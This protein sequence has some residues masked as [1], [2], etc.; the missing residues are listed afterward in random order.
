METDWDKP[1]EYE[2]NRVGEPFTAEP[3]SLD[4]F[5]AERYRLFAYNKKK[6][7]LMSGQVHHAPYP[8]QQVNLECYS[9]RLFVLNGL[10]KPG[11][12]PVS[13]LASAGV[14]VQIYPMI[15]VD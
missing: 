1:Q 3:G 5:L 4:F 10:S 7:Q 9:K 8:L 6:T 15:G 13:L 12:S 11:N 2:W 14:D